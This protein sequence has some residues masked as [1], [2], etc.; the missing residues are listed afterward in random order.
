M[1]EELEK[2]TSELSDLNESMNQEQAFGS[3]EISGMMSNISHMQAGVQNKNEQ[4][5]CLEKAL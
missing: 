1:K 2:L 5:Q 3:N 4:L